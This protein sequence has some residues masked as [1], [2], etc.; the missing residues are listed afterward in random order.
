MAF[1]EQKAF[2]ADS[3]YRR[4]DMATSFK[5]IRSLAGNGTSS[6]AV[7]VKCK[8]GALTMSEQQ[9]QERWQEHFAE[10]FGGRIVPHESLAKVS[11][12]AVKVTSHSIDTTPTNT[13]NALAKLKRNRAVGRDAMPSELLQSGGSL[14]T[15]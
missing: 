5:I 3:A 8:D 2:E 9:R 12:P 6:G 14:V 4:H 15:P 13:L 7:P 10:V 11:P 1:L